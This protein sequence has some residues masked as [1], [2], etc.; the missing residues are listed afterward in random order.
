MYLIF[1]KEKAIIEQRQMM[2]FSHKL[3]QLLDEIPACLAYEHLTDKYH[4]ESNICKEIR[5]AAIMIDRMMEENRAYIERKFN[6]KLGF[7]HE[8]TFG[9]INK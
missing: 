7:W 2:E 5:H 8:S 3:E 6:I 1:E 9:D 4:A